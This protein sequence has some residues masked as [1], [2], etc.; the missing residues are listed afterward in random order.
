LTD[1]TIGSGVVTIGAS[2]FESCTHLTEVTIPDNVMYIYS[3]AFYGCTSLN[4]VELGS[5]VLEIG[6]Y[7]FSSCLSL[8]EFYAKP[9][10]AP[11]LGYNV[12]DKSPISSI[13]VPTA[14][15]ADYQSKWSSYSSYLK[16]YNF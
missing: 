14:S 5:G 1:L 11:S 16:G 3:D 4:K 8:A 10:S 2:A 9:L 6:Q 13:F 15:L 7:A 12:F